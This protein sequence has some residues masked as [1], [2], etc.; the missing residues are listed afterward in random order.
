MIEFKKLTL[1]T[2]ETITPYLEQ[3]PQR[4][5]DWTIAGTYI[6][7]DL[8]HYEYA[9]AADNLIFRLCLDDHPCA[10]TVPL[11]GDREEGLILLEQYAA[12]RGAELCFAIVGQADLP[13]LRARYPHMIVKTNRD[14]YDYLYEVDDLLALKGR[15]HR[16]TRNNINRFM[17]RYPIH[18]FEVLTRDNMADA[19]EFMGRY[20]E[21]EAEGS[22]LLTEESEKITEV[23]DNMERYR[24]FG[25]L[26]YVADE[27]VG[28]S[29]GEIMHDTLFVHVE[30]ANTGYRGAYQML[31]KSF[32]EAFA[33][34]GITYVNR[35]DDNGDEGLRQSKLS[36][37]PCALLEKYTVVA[38]PEA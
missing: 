3:H 2:L 27:P 16:S 15:V 25:G 22:E 28:L 18:R 17:R 23:L 21:A 26:L 36:Y 13:I 4:L 19:H 10:F 34:D 30:K 29:L 12:R 38:T 11:G 32:L 14:Y 31:M 7:R 8:Y 6:W 37:N 1:D 20:T 35:E 24:A 5:C 33:A 9:F